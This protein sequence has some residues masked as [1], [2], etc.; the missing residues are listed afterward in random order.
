MITND[1]GIVG[2]KH[3]IIE[4]MARLAWKGEVTAED[5]EELVYKIIPGPLAQ[6]R[7]LGVA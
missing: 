3:K 6:Y 5:K 4:E 7:L 2:F 1:A